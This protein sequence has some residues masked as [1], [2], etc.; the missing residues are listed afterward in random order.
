M[1][2]KVEIMETR[3]HAMEIQKTIKQGEAYTVENIKLKDRI[4]E[5]EEKVNHNLTT[6]NI[7]GKIDIKPIKEEMNKLIDLDHERN[8]IHFNLIIFCLKE[9]DMLSIVKTKLYNRLQIETISLIEENRVGKLIENKERLIRV[10]VSFTEQEYKILKK[11][12][13]LKGLG[14]FINEYLIPEDYVELR[15]E[16]QK[17]K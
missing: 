3:L 9:E 2:N 14:I 16:V 1:E 11:T 4:K 15:N 12:S 8:K 10:K 13:S 6:N 7:E 5:L 17:V